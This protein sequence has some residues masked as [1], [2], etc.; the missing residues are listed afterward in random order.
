[1]ALDL[2]SGSP[3]KKRKKTLQ[4]NDVNR[5]R[6]MQFIAEVVF[7]LHY[8]YSHSHFINTPTSPSLS[9]L[10]SFSSIFLL[11]FPLHIF[12]THKKTPPSTLLSFS[13]PIFKKSSCVAACLTSMLCYF[14]VPYI[15]LSSS[16]RRCVSL[17]GMPGCRCAQ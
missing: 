16:D 15:R 11:L 6:R 13:R 8:I 5:K 1:M 14:S 12:I 3:Q 7:F 17:S 4:L 9:G 10:K 2:Q